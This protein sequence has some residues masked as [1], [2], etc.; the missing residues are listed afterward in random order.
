LATHR[1]N[2]TK[3]IALSLI[4]GEIIGLSKGSLSTAAPIG[5]ADDL[6]LD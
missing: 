4:K 5:K 3:R 2:K 6:T 1:N